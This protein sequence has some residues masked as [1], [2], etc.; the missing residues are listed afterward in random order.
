MTVTRFGFTKKDMKYLLSPRPINTRPERKVSR[1][2]C[3][4]SYISNTGER[5]QNQE[6]QYG[7]NNQGQL[8]VESSNHASNKKAENF[9]L[10]G[11]KS[12]RSHGLRSKAS[13]TRK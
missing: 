10:E 11:K 13:R 9:E 4:K 8:R 2:E 12:I 6:K 1:L 5:N 3:Q 7:V